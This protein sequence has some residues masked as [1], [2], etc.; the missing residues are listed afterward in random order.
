MEQRQL[1][2]DA[3][4]VYTPTGPGLRALEEKLE[5][6]DSR[7]TI[8]KRRALRLSRDKPWCRPP[9]RFWE[10]PLEEQEEPRTVSVQT[11]FPPVQLLEELR[12]NGWDCHHHAT[13]SNFQNLQGVVLNP[14]PV[15]SYFDRP[16]EPEIGA[17]SSEK[18]VNAKGLMR[19]L[20]LWRLEPLP[21]ISNV[22][23]PEGGLWPRSPP[24]SSGC[25]APA[26][27]REEI[28][29]PRCHFEA[30]KGVPLRHEAT[31]EFNHK[32]TW[33]CPFRGLGGLNPLLTLKLETE[34]ICY[35]M[36][37]LRVKVINRYPLT[38]SLLTTLPSP[39]LLHRRHAW[40]GRH[41]PPVTWFYS[42]H[43]SLLELDP[44]IVEVGLSERGQIL[45]SGSP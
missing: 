24:L 25:G 22:Q 15:R 21:G 16:R 18:K 7:E 31:P 38:R 2:R 34:G 26:R 41:Q 35:P 10:L 9:S 43:R 1:E 32:S 39:E 14:A 4:V 37:N 33:S 11:D 36:R 13:W 19:I 5:L 28:L 45:T 40:N 27:P 29:G 12:E 42:S 23:L 6:R 20:P 8:L 17:R 30:L 3:R 44:A